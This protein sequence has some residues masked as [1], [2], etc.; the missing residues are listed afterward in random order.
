[1]MYVGMLR[2]APDS[3]EFSFWVNYRDSGNSGPALING[4]LAAPE[5]RNRFLP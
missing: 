1:M 3:G 5:Y 4:F 2:R